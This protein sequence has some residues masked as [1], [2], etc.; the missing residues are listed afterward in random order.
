[1]SGLAGRPTSQCHEGNAPAPQE[2]AGAQAFVFT[3]EPGVPFTT[4]G[5]GKMV[6]RL[7]HTS[8]VSPAAAKSYP[9]RREVVRGV[10]ALRTDRLTV[11]R[12]PACEGLALDDASR[13]TALE[14]DHQPGPLP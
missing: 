7:D 10:Y 4:S 5:F 12:H 1:M 9:A 6:A 13:I 2:R 3:S 11:P 14:D 8:R